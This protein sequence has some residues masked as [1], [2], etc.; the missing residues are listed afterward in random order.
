[1]PKNFLG[2]LIYFESLPRPL[3]WL[4]LVMVTV[5]IGIVD[6]AS[7][8]E[9]SVAPLYLVPV[10]VSA[11]SLGQGPGLAFSFIESLTLV[12]SNWLAGQ[13][14]SSA[15]MLV[16]N[17][18]L[19]GTAY[20][21]VASLAAT[22]RRQVRQAEQL[23]L[24]D[25]LTGAWNRRAFYQSVA[26]EI[27]RLERCGGP[28]SLA[29]IDLDDFKIIN[30]RFGHEKGDKVLRTL[31]DVCNA[32]LRGSDLVGRLGGDEFVLLLAETDATM[33]RKMLPRLV[34]KIKSGLG[35][36]VSLSVGAVTCT[37][38]PEDV[39]AIIRHADD[40]MYEVKHA[41]KNDIRYSI[42]PDETDSMRAGAS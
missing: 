25:F 34:D 14:Y 39:E 38:S 2:F 19:R 27:A 41:T 9:A 16:W 24:T 36:R 7:G 3:A 6:Y 10:L 20:V 28:F 42:Y 29:Y 15:W 22:F 21:I 30:D 23:A 8:I 17:I 12:F 4:V 18:V 31:V 40:L 5:L 32:N 11:W 26:K 1:M 33:L 37:R 13:A 35:N